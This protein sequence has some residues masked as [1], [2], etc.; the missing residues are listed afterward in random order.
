VIV[1]GVGLDRVDAF[2]VKPFSIG[3]LAAGPRELVGAR[4]S[5]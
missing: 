3:R 5:S 1:L 4:I 2:L